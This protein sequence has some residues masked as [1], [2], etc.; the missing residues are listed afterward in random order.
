MALDA[1]QKNPNSPTQVS[2][3]KASAT[4]ALVGYAL[5][6]LI[7]V[8]YQERDENYN[9][10][11]RQNRINARKIKADEVGKIRQSK[12]RSELTDTFIKMY[13]SKKLLPANIRKLKSPLKDDIF[14]MVKRLNEQARESIF[15]GKKNLNAVTKSIRPTHIFVGVGL[16]VG[17]LGAVVTTI[18]RRIDFYNAQYPD[19]V[20][21]D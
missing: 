8:T 1:L 14:D 12:N 4:G 19:N 9:E 16:V 10:V 15:T 7:P 6:Y 13:D 20:E 18:I 17:F 3:I 21:F 2:Y 5:K 11:I